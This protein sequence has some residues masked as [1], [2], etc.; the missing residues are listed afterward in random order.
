MK[1]HKASY[2]DTDTEIYSDILSHHRTEVRR[3][4]GQRLETRP[5]PSDS[6]SSTPSS[7]ESKT[8]LL[9]FVSTSTVTVEDD[10]G[11]RGW[12]NSNNM[13]GMQFEEN[14]DFELLN[15]SREIVCP[16]YFNKT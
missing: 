13:K 15:F 1:I 4:L 7:T 14:D 3:R 16:N 11:T 6:W 10:V 2:Y 5:F 8:A 9:C 12:G